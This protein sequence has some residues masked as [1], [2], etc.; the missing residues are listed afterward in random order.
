[1]TLDDVTS[2]FCLYNESSRSFRYL[3][4]ISTMLQYVRY[5][6]KL[7]RRPTLRP[8]RTRLSSAS[9]R[10]LPILT[11]SQSSPFTLD[12]S[13]QIQIVITRSHH[14]SFPLFLFLSYTMRKAGHHRGCHF[15]G[16]HSAQNWCRLRGWVGISGGSRVSGSRIEAGSSSVGGCVDASNAVESRLVD[17][18]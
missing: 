13:Q 6:N 12:S 17:S 8:S 10:S 9:S 5:E 4:H 18:R 7:G 15:R 1:M 11:C 16:H 14:L 2:Y 3:T